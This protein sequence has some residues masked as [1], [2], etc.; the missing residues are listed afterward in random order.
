MQKSQ[1]LN[2]F[3]TQQNRLNK[4]EIQNRRKEIK[5]MRR[6]KKGNKKDAMNKENKRLFK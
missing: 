2:E 4:K 5:K 1:L 6:S 3:I